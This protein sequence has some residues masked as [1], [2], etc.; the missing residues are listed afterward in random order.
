MLARPP[1]LAN[2][3]TS[4][5]NPWVPYPEFLMTYLAVKGI[6]LLPLATSAPPSNTHIGAVLAH[7][8]AKN[9][10]PCLLISK[11]GK[12]A[13]SVMVAAYRRC[14][15]GWAE[16]G[17]A[18]EY[19]RVC[20]ADERAEAD[21]AVVRG[22]RPGHGVLEEVE[23]EEGFVGEGEGEEAGWIEEAGI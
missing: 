4:H 10:L 11:K 1:S 6:T 14:V 9:T 13:V 21:L 17:W 23:W 8:T 20:G 12:H 15:Q 7:L 3:R 19:R 5:L 22:L 2:A 16:E 18:E